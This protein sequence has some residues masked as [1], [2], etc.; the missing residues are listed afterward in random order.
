MTGDIVDD[1]ERETGRIWE[2]FYRKE[3]MMILDSID[4][5]APAAP[6]IAAEVVVSVTVA[7]SSSSCSFP[8]VVTIVPLP[9]RPHCHSIVAF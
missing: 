5:F 6:K 3:K 1:V 8:V 2:L 4:R 9:A 7:I